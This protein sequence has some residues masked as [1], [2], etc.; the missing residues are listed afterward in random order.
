M[1]GERINNT[2][3]AGTP[4]DYVYA[5]IYLYNGAPCI[6]GVVVVL[7]SLVHVC[8]NARLSE[9]TLCQACNVLST[10]KAY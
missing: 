5:R 2:Q 7:I 8:K 9:D 10:N 4:E 6:L 1:R 3:G